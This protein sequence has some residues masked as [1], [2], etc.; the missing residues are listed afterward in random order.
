MEDKSERNIFFKIA[1]FTF[2]AYLFFML[3]GTKIPFKPRLDESNMGGG[4]NIANQVIFTS[5]FLLSL[6][7]LVVRRLDAI[8]I[9]KREKLLTIFLI[10]CIL[11]I[12]WSYSPI[13]S[14]KRLFRTISLFTVILSLLVH[15]TSTR[16]ILSFIKPILFLYIFLSLIACVTIHGA[17][18][19]QFNTWRGFE[20]TKNNLGAVAVVCIL[21]SFFIYK[22]EN[23]YSKLLAAAAVVFS[24]GL[25]FGAR[26]MTSILNFL[27][28]VFLASLISI[29][30]VFKPLGLGRSASIILFLFGITVVGSVVFISPEVIGT[31]AES[32]GKDPSFS[33]RTDLWTAMFISIMQHPILGTGYQAFWSVVP[34][35]PYLQH[36]FKLFVW[37]PNESHNGFIDIA[38]E[39]GFV[40][41]FI[42]IV[43]LIRYFLNLR[44]LSKPDIWK[45]LIIAAIIGNM[46]ESYLIAFQQTPG[47]MVMIS[48][49]I[50]YAK[51]WRQ[52]EGEEVFET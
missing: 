34:P 39:V 6:I 30:E 33:G 32:V 45:W 13:D 28:I 11:S 47:A 19:P 18:D 2:M 49:L 14:A 31:F 10:W 29:D 17:I 51:L 38:N 46:Q 27:I 23:G 36:I 4:G 20:D 41:L 21:L 43:L 22:R 3:F 16:E 12:F 52:D 24:I 37:I 44:K 5:L 15:T 9:I 1:I 50:L 48:Y 35:S 42:F 26:S 8:D 25:L 7:S 40:G